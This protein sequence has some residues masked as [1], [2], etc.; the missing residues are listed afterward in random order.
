G[1]YAWVRNPIYSAFMILCTGVIL[2]LGNLYFLILP[3]IFWIF[4]TILMKHTEEVWLKDLYGKEYEDYCKR[5]NRCWP[6]LPGKDR[7][8]A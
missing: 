6:W 4:M 1:A 8:S 5:V 7:H 2:I 3:L